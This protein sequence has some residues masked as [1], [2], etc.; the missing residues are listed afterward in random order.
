[1]YIE[2]NE[3]KYPCAKP[4]FGAFLIWPGV[5]DLPFPV[6]GTITTCAD[7][8][9]VMR[10][11]NPGEWLRQTYDNNVLTLT[12]AP[13][14]EPYEPGEEPEPVVH[15]T[16]EQERTDWLEAF[17]LASGYTPESEVE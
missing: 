11:D 16:T 3:T 5:E 8:G 12:N 9:F 4:S 6:A 13:E 1:M 14:P 17:I 7:D 15:R 2:I 10:E